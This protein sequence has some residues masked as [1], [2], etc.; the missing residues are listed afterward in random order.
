MASVHGMFGLVIFVACTNLSTAGRVSSVHFMVGGPG[1]VLPSAHEYESEVAGALGKARFAGLKEELI[2]LHRQRP[3]D[4][5][6]CIE[7]TRAWLEKSGKEFTE[8]QL[9]AFCKEMMCE[10]GGCDAEPQPQPQPE[11]QPVPAP[12]PPPKPEKPRLR[13]NMDEL[14]NDANDAVP[15]R[16]GKPGDDVPLRGGSKQVVPAFLVASIGVVG[17]YAM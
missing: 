8:Q 15:L 6:E 5:A 13:D 11:P 3:E 9:H 7:V 1:S 2:K 14:S 12:S 10:R 4:M 17:A 16:T